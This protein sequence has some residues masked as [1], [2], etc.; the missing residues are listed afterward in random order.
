MVERDPD[1]SAYY[2]ISVG[3]EDFVCIQLTVCISSAVLSQINE[4]HLTR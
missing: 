3:S 1:F 4:T 2:D